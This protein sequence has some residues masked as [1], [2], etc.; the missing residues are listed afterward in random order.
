[1]VN[2]QLLLVLCKSAYN[3][4]LERTFFTSLDIVIFILHLK[5]KYHNIYD[6]HI[7]VHVDLAIARPI[8]ETFLKNPTATTFQKERKVKNVGLSNQS[9]LNVNITYFDARLDKTL[10][11]DQRDLLNEAKVKIPMPIPDEEYTIVQLY[12]NPSTIV[13]IRVELRDLV[14]RILIKC[15][16]TKVNIFVI[17]PTETPDI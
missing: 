7:I 9:R 13:K 4:I 17:S 10:V 6:E 15:L 14:E 11:D 3:Y 2:V 8:H 1:M 12:E 16:K 5:M